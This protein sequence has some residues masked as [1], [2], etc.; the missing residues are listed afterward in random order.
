[1]LR[2]I[3]QFTGT[4]VSIPFAVFVALILT[5]LLSQPCLGEQDDVVY[6]L[7]SGSATTSTLVPDP[8]PGAIPLN[9]NKTV[10]LLIDG[11]QHSLKLNPGS[12]GSA[13]THQPLPSLTE[14]RHQA[15]LKTTLPPGELKDEK[16]LLFYYDTTP[17][18]LTLVYPTSTSYE[19]H[20]THFIIEFSDE[21]SGIPATLSEI[22]LTAKINGIAASVK[23]VNEDTTRS[24]LISPSKIQ[25][26]PYDEILLSVSIKDRAGN[27]TAREFAFT[28]NDLNWTTDITH[29]NCRKKA[30]V[31][32][33]YNIHTRYHYPATIKE[34]HLFFRPV[35]T[36]KDPIRINRETNTAE[37]SFGTVETLFSPEYTPDNDLDILLNSVVITTDHSA[38]SVRRIPPETAGNAISFKYEVTQKLSITPN[39]Q[40]AW[41]KVE[42]PKTISIRKNPYCIDAPMFRL[43]LSSE[44]TSYRFPI[45]LNWQGE[46]AYEIVSEQ[47]KDAYFITYNTWTDPVLKFLDTSASYL[48]HNN[49]H[50]FFN[51]KD[52]TYIGK[53]PVP[54]EGYYSFSTVLSNALGIWGDSQKT[55]ANQTHTT[56]VNFG[57]PVIKGFRYD[58]ETEELSAI[59]RD[60]GTPPDKLR[61]TLNITD[62]GQR[63]FETTV[64][65]DGSIKLIAFF[66][67]PTSLLQ[68]ELSV[69]DLANNRTDAATPILGMPEPEPDQDKKRHTFKDSEEISI[70]DDLPPEDFSILA[71]QSSGTSLVRECS[72]HRILSIGSI[73]RRFN[74]DKDLIRSF[75][76]K[77]YPVDSSY[78]TKF[79]Y[80]PGEII[81][82]SSKDFIQVESQDVDGGESLTRSVQSSY[83]F[84]IDQ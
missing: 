33:P 64:Q 17:P 45:L 2:S 57:A 19:R 26:Y 52:R 69:F 13:T 22:D 62:H 40:I 56:L 31:P 9:N 30:V 48:S 51:E 46:R 59:I 14:G 42:H 50:Y 54:H 68:A 71:A 41:I 37:F 24:L 61:I 20:R 7:S 12:N 16:Q 81:H 74:Q 39:K 35:L 84:T 11:K 3:L 53:I 55:I 80:Y 65:D 4:R 28:E 76:Y 58:R 60:E 63:S 8:A 15:T 1:M 77:Y 44:R 34:D 78:Q 70:A 36:T 73:F 38:I 10:K 67:M 32:P 82:Q 18:E 21:G 29:Y 27:E 5:I 75:S 43:T 72:W 83:P 49:S 47:D 23:V 6:Y 66:P 25:L 79:K